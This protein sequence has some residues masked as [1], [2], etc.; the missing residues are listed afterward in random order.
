M[1]STF[2][3]TRINWRASSTRPSRLRKNAVSSAFSG[4]GGSKLACPP[5]GARPVR[6]DGRARSEAGS[7]RVAREIA[8]PDQVVHRQAK[9]K[10]P[11]DPRHPAMA[12]LPQQPDLFEPA[13]DLFDPLALALAH[14]IAGVACGAA[15]DRTRTL[16]GVLRHMRGH[17]EAAE[18]VHEVPRVIA[19]V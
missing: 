10:H 14:Q 18:A 3:L 12:R 8:H 13:E 4:L 16:R 19:L 7:Y 1:R 6:R 5:S 17:C 2:H 9:G 15:I 11:A